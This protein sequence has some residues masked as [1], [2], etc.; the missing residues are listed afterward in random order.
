LSNNDLE[1]TLPSS[2]SA[3]EN[4]GQLLLHNNMKLTGTLPSTW[5]TFTRLNSF[6]MSGH[7]LSGGLPPSYSAMVSLSVV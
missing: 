4:L 3:L 6:S 5:S 1:G 7:Q 2:W